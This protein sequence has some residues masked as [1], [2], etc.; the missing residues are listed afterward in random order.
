MRSRRILYSAM[1]L[2]GIVAVARPAAAITAGDVLDKMNADQR[3]T[4]LAGTIEMAAF[5]AG[6]GGNK[7][8]AECI[9]DWYY[10]KTGTADVVGGLA[11]FKDRQALPVIYFFIKK[12]CGE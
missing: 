3:G 5:L 1:I 11:Q 9:V 7:P 4:Y 8:R 10:N 6:L 2:L 12:A